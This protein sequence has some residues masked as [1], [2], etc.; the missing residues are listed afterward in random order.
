LILKAAGNQNWDVV[1]IRNTI[2]RKPNVG[3]LGYPVRD[4]KIEDCAEES[5]IS[6]GDTNCTINWWRGSCE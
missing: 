3:V 5:T 1:I 6:W 4:R 2:Y